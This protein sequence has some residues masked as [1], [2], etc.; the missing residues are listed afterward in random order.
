MSLSGQTHPAVCFPLLQRRPVKIASV[1]YQCQGVSHS[2]MS[3]LH[4]QSHGHGT[5]RPL[6]RADEFRPEH[7]GAGIQH[8]RSQH[9]PS[10]QGCSGQALRPP[11][12]SISHPCVS[13]HFSCFESQLLTQLL[14]GKVG[15]MARLAASPSRHFR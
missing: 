10:G 14:Q 2:K 15:S 5:D 3:L 8:F 6:G 1:I 9:R 7:R 4:P 11:W 13:G 12:G